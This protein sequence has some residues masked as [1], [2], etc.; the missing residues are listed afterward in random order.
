MLEAQSPRNPPIALT[1]RCLRVLA[2]GDWLTRQRLLAWCAI[3]LAGEI[4]DFLFCV[5]GT[6]G[7][8]VPLPKPVTTDFISFYAAGALADAGHPALA[9]HPAAHYAAEQQLRQPGIDYVFFFYPPVFL[10]LCALL[11]KLPYLLAFVTF[12]LVTAAFWLRLMAAILRLPPAL[13]L[14]PV[15]AFPAV[16]WTFGTGQNAFLNAAL[17]GAGTLLVDRRPGLAGIAF[18]TLCYKPHFGLLLPLALASGRH[19]R[20]FIAATLT[21]AALVV[22]S[23]E[24]F[25]WA[26]WHDFLPRLLGARQTFI[27]GQ[28]TL[29][30]LLTPFGAMLLTG[31]APRW[32]YAVQ[33]T[34]SLLVAITVGRVWWRGGALAPRAATLAAGTLLAIPIALTYDELLAAIAGAWLIR[35]GVAQGFRRW[36][37][38]VLAIGY[39][40]PAVFPFFDRLYALPLAPLPIA[41]L[42]LIATLRA[43][44]T[45]RA[46]LGAISAAKLGA[47]KS[48]GGGAAD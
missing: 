37:K 12:Q 39:V 25:G 44:R 38:T 24:W 14:L 1:R 42:L 45:D 17:F 47:P 43:A 23:G 8:I 20:A 36:E 41:A 34:T 35:D 21:A 26:C 29:A 2:T 28:V 22:L 19:W 33:A 18:G 32:A 16:F 48:R 40:C 46:P 9:Y 13:W 31:A 3:L 6:H 10:L 5:A 15:I 11:A 7:W 30:H 4:A 27:A